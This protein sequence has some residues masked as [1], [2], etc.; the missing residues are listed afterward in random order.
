MG[1]CGVF[2]G[3]GEV[4]DGRA[5]ANRRLTEGLKSQLVTIGEQVCHAQRPKRRA[6]DSAG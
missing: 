2:I 5:N 3:D 1:V 4:L 6:M